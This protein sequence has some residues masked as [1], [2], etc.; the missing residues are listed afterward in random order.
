MQEH[1]LSVE[2]R[3]KVPQPK[4]GLMIP[5]TLPGWEGQGSAVHRGN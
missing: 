2:H 4:A 5:N 3:S 1:S